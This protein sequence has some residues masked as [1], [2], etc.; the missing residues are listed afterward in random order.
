MDQSKKTKVQTKIQKAIKDKKFKVSFREYGQH[1]TFVLSK[2]KPIADL[3]VINY[4]LD[5][6]DYGKF[7]I[8]VTNLIDK[9]IN[10]F[11]ANDM[12]DNLSDSIIENG[13]D[14]YS[15]IKPE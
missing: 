8:N 1:I 12:V 3:K 2:G 15:F 6:K 10:S 7:G 11:L 13:L 4:F 14:N 9:N 5:K